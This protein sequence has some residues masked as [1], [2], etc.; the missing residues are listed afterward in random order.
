MSEVRVTVGAAEANRSF[1]KLLKRV[2]QEGA[3]VTITSHNRPVAELVP[4]SS[5]ISD[6]AREKA[7]QALEIFEELRAKYPPV[8]GERWTRDE[9]YDFLGE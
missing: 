6:E 2:D 9:L 7:R 8:H 3:R 4:P 1:S 5:T